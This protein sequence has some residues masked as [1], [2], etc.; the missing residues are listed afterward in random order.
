MR[1]FESAYNA[2]FTNEKRCECVR[3]SYMY[4]RLNEYSCWLSGGNC[5]RQMIINFDKNMVFLM[6]LAIYYMD[7]MFLL[8]R[9]TGVLS[10]ILF[11]IIDMSLW[12]YGAYNKYLD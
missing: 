11:N 1:V 8:F 12:L 4:K 7:F 6:C 5:E 3:S 9:L 10:N 2:H